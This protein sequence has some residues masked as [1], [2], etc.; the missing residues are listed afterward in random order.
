M[1]T[2]LARDNG[3]QR[4]NFEVLDRLV[5]PGET[6][7]AG[8]DIL[9]HR[10]PQPRPVRWLDRR[11]MAEIEAQSP[12]ERRAFMLELH[13]AP[14]KAVVAN[15]RTDELP[16][17]LHRYLGIRFRPMFGS[18]ST[19]APQ[20]DRET[21]RVAIRFAG[22]YLL[23]VSP[24]TSRVE[25]DGQSVAPGTRILLSSGVHRA[26][27]D[28]YCQL[29]VVLADLP[30]IADARFAERRPFFEDVYDY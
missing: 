6:Y 22:E 27:L 9:Y 23:H 17:E 13:A 12:E 7:L 11:R 25:I 18:I 30:N 2:V 1:P 24:G 20:C 16:E 14:I 8:T 29:Q 3:Y 15:F 19:A 4:S 5:G 28:G 10:P 26:E 21:S